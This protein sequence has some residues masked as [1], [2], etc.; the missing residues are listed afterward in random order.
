MGLEMTVMFAG[1]H[2]EIGF[3]SAMWGGGSV[4]SYHARSPLVSPR[5][6]SQ[7]HPG[8]SRRADAQLSCLPNATPPGPAGMPGERRRGPSGRAQPPRKDTV[9]AG[10]WWENVLPLV[11]LLV[12]RRWSC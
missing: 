1:T 5:A 3:F 10:G 6:P 2:E 7:G 12:L 11:H 8:Y 4:S 9:H